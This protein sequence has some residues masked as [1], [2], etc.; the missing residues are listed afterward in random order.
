MLVKLIRSPSEAVW[1]VLGALLMRP[2]FSYAHLQPGLILPLLRAFPAFSLICLCGAWL[3]DLLVLG[4][5]HG[6]DKPLVTNHPSLPGT[7]GY[8]EHGSCSAKGESP[9]K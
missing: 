6:W 3:H 7:E 5:G 2:Y 8:L 4:K 9:D 1:P